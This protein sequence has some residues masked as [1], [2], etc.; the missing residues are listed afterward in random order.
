M[1][2]ITHILASITLIVIASAMISS[3]A[4]VNLF[5]VAVVLTVGGFVAA[6]Y[7]PIGVAFFTLTNLSW[8]QGQQNMGGII[9]DIYYCPI[10][11][12]ETFPVASAAGKLRYGFQYD[13][14][15]CL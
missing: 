12:I 3:T 11:D 8:T 14:E 7:T 4:E 5:A 9:G 2:R 6:K 10:E 13:R 15:F 1:K